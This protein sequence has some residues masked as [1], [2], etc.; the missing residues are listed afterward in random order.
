LG[1]EVGDFLASLEGVAADDGVQLILLVCWLGHRLDCSCS[2]LGVEQWKEHCEL[3]AS[4]LL[5][6]NYDMIELVGFK[7]H[8][9]LRLQ[10]TWVQVMLHRHD[11]LVEFSEYF[12]F[13]KEDLHR[14]STV[15]VAYR[16]DACW[17][18]RV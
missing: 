5:V 11:T 13:F 1:A 3:N 12:S 14:A 4:Q 17:F 7:C 16:N 6:A 18:G 2:N 15:E 8:Y 10:R 9:C